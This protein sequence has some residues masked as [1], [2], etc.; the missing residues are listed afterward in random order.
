MDNSARMASMTSS[1]LQKAAAAVG[2]VFLLVGIL[3]FIPG[4]TTHYSTMEFGGHHSDAKL[5]GI[6]EVSILHNIVHLLFGVAGLA[7]ARS[8][9]GARAYLLGGGAIYL[10]LWVYGLLVGKES[11]AN[12]V[13]VN[14]ADNWLHLLLGLGMV[15]LGFLLGKRDRHGARP[16]V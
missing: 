15:A 1:D 11:S 3:G 16:A 4:I 10:V 5:L 7:L 6:F 2:A 14:D 12:F 8:W 13:P 9:D